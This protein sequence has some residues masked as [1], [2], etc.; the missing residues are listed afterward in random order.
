MIWHILRVLVLLQKLLMRVEIILENLY[1]NMFENDNK[2]SICKV[3][4]KEYFEYKYL[5]VFVMNI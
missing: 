4:L 1:E 3:E 5:R 2:I